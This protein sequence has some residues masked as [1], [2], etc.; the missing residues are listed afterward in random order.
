MSEHLKLTYFR[1]IGYSEGLFPPPPKKKKKSRYMYMG[2]FADN[3]YEV[4]TDAQFIEW[5]T[6]G[7]K[8]DEDIAKPPVAGR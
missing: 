2:T 6:F 7:S 1:R 4:M 5:E 8:A 3:I